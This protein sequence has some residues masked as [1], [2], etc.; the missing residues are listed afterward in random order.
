MAIETELKLRIAPDQLARLKRH[1]LLKAIAVSRPVTRRLY[2]IYFDTPKLELHKTGMALRLRRAGKQWLQTL[3]GGGS[4]QAG[5]HQRNEW[6]VPVRGPALDFALPDMADWDE[7]LPL[8]LRRKLQPVFVTDFSR[9]SR[10]LNFRGAEIELCMD[11]G[12]VST[13]QHSVTICEL[14]LELKS[15]QPR[16]L[17]ELALAIL[18]V[19]PFELEMVSK[20][21]QGYRLLSGYTDKPVKGTVPNIA[22]TDTLAD[23]LQRLIWSCL[24]HLQNNL[25]GAMKSDDAEYLH[26]M[27]VALRRLRVVLRMAE[28]FRPDGKLAALRLEISAL[29]IAL[30]HVRELDVFIAQTVQPMCKRMAGHTGLQAL[31][32]TCE[33]QRSDCYAALRG[34]AQASELQRLILDFS[35]WMSGAYWQQQGGTEARARDFATR[36]LRK[37]AKRFAQYGKQLNTVDAERLHALRILAKKLR[38]SAEFFAGL[39]DRQKTRA[40]LAALSEVQEVLGQINDVAVAHRLLDELAKDAALSAHQ[41]A[42]VLAKGWIAHDLSHQFAELHSAVRRFNRNGAFWER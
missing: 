4:V 8:P 31:L 28:K 30:G 34:A 32:A 22:G 38:Y 7:H 17:F 6:E 39:Y 21:E 5:L 25:R 42:M 26:Q 10:M 16:H 40:F 3:K 12:Q 41:E 24:Q 33:R 35:I 37:L 15:G 36:R 29:C 13:E 23:V 11:H 14:E 2:N 27:R 18:E 9:T 1:A 20:A 19:V